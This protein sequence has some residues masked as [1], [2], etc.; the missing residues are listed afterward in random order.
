MQNQFNIKDSGVVSDPIE[1]NK[2]VPQGDKLWPLLFNLFLAD[3]SPVLKEMKCADFF[4]ADNVVS[5]TIIIDNVH[6][7]MK[8]LSDIVSKV[9]MSL[10]QKKST[11]E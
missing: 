3:L 7:A 1:T 10:K 4:F 5:V 9:S 6:F 2:A 11:F 8:H